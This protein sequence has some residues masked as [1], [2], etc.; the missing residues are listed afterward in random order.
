MVSCKLSHPFSRTTC[1]T[2]LPSHVVASAAAGVKAGWDSETRERGKL[3]QL[4][5]YR[6]TLSLDALSDAC[7]QYFVTHTSAKVLSRM[8][9]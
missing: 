4:A 1:K 6:S 3:D 8:A 9:R 7:Q 2:H 5:I